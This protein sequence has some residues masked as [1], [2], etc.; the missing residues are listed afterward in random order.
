MNTA[1]L[2]RHLPLLLGELYDVEVVCGG[3]GADTHPGEVPLQEVAG[4]S[5]NIESEE[6][7]KWANWQKIGENQEKD[8]F[9]FQALT[10]EVQACRTT[11]QN[12]ASNNADC[13]LAGSCG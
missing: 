9:V 2:T 1:P 5:T 11:V 6:D 3:L 4:D 10:P 12:I 8:W 7:S 13:G